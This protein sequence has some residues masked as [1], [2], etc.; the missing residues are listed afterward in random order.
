M[1]QLALSRYVSLLQVKNRALPKSIGCGKVFNRSS[2]KTGANS[3]A[4][5]G[6]A[7]STA[8]ATAATTG[9][10]AAGGAGAPATDAG[11]ADAAGDGGSG[12]GAGGGGGGRVWLLRGLKEVETWV[13]Q[14]ANEQVRS[15]LLTCHFHSRA[16]SNVSPA[17]WRSYY[18]QV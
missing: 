13:R 4:R 7:H 15:H 14:L 3:P 6:G 12:G 1:N 18:A 10:G 11:V 5:P 16:M 9:G 17:G 2:W 8:A